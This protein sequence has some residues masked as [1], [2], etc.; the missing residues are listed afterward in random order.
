MGRTSGVVKKK[1]LGG[2]GARG[3]I[4]SYL[5]RRRAI[6]HQKF[7]NFDQI[8]NVELFTP[9]QKVNSSRIPDNPRVGVIVAASAAINLYSYLPFVGK[10]DQH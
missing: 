2:V 6:C 9:F 8:S 3:F 10:I 4:L 5:T 7:G 1:K